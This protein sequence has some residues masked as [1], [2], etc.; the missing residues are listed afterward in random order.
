MR[1]IFKRAALGAAAMLLLGGQWAAADPSGGGKPPEVK[2]FWAVKV[3]SYKLLP[4]GRVD[5]RDGSVKGYGKSIGAAME[6]AKKR[7]AAKHEA[8]GAPLQTFGP[9]TWD[10]AMA[11]AGLL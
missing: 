6:M 4:D 8:I 2:D 3:G 1:S 5:K 10:K 7:A 9:M 11:K